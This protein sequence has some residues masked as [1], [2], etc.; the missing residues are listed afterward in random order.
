MLRVITHK[1][2]LTALTLALTAIFITPAQAAD[3]LALS[4]DCEVA[5]ARSALPKRLR[6]ETSVYALVGD[7][8]EKV[9]EG[10]GPFTCIVERNHPDSVIPQC[11]D[12]EGIDT[13]LPAIIDRSEMVLAGADFETIEAANQ[14]KLKGGL[15][16][17]ADRAGVNYMMSE[18]NFI[19]VASAGAVLKVPPH[20]MFYAPGLTNEEVGGSFQSMVENL[21]TPFVFRPGPHGYMLTYAENGADPNEVAMACSG[22]LGERPPSFNPSS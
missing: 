8:Y 6:E 12:R 10:S 7:H 22:Q 4:Q 1:L 17:T 21:G 16:K 14:Q 13:V 11:M 19:Y 3:R 20:V 15:Y 9:I 18:Y 2:C 5:I